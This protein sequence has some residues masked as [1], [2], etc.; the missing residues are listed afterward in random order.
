MFFL[1]LAEGHFSMKF[2]VFSF[3]VVISFIFVF[4]CGP[5]NPGTIAV[6]VKVTQNGSPL[7]RAIV[8]IISSDDKGYSAS[9]QT[10]SD[11]VAKLHT[12]D[13]WDGAF[14]G[15]YYVGISKSE[16]IVFPAPTAETPD[17][18]RTEQKELL[19]AKYKQHQNSG[20]TLTVGSKRGEVHTFDIP[21]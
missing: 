17:A 1:L 9:G 12:T 11:G 5:K 4:G 7:D 14:P 2:K 16:K 20:F 8:S 10:D 3:F 15:A 13:G 19:P 18:T 6:S 21:E